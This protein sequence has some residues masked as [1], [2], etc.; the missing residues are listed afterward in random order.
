MGAESAGGAQGDLVHLSG[1]GA[2]QIVDEVEVLRNLVLGQAGQEEL[3]QFGSVRRLCPGFGRDDDESVSD[4]APTVIGCGDDR[5][6]GDCGV[7][8][9]CGFHLSGVDVLP[10]GDEHV[11]QSVDDEEEPV[12]VEVADVAGVEP[13]TGGERRIGGG[14]VVPV[15]VGDIG[16]ADDDLTLDSRRAGV[17]RSVAD[18]DLGEGYG[19]SC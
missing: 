4:L 15:A 8:E 2:R 19:S 6:L 5:G 3:A 10:A 1:T 11:L 7:I 17:A 9:E 13:A 16:S 18:L 12:G 14:L